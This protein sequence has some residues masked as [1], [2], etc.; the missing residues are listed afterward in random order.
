M[1]ESSGRTGG[2]DLFSQ[3]RPVPLLRVGGQRCLRKEEEQY[4]HH[5]DREW[6]GYSLQQG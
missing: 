5:P 3:S 4:V 2:T 6:A 1:P